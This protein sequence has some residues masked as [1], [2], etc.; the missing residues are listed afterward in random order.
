MIQASEGPKHGGFQIY[1]NKQPKL[2]SFCD[3]IWKNRF[4]YFIFQ[5]SREKMYSKGIGT[6]LIESA[7]M[8]LF[9]RY[10]KSVLSKCRKLQSNWKITFFFGENCARYNVNLCCSENHLVHVP[11]SILLLKVFLP[12]GITLPHLLLS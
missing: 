10:I 3:S 8:S 12:C 4:I 9:Q 1:F 11:T 6:I 7:K 5:F 2:Y